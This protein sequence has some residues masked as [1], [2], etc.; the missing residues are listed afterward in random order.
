MHK[1][2]QL[3]L[4]CTVWFMCI[5]AASLGLDKISAAEAHTF[6]NDDQLIAKGGGHH[7]GHHHHH[8]HHHHH[9]HH[10][11]HH[12]HGH[13]HHGW[14]HGGWN[15]NNYWNGGGYWGD[16]P[17]YFNDPNYYYDN[18]GIPSVPYTTVLPE[19]GTLGPT[20]ENNT[21]IQN[22]PPLINQTT[23]KQHASSTTHTNVNK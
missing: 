3:V 6:L 7:G 9:G 23:P 21:L 13:H 15:H 22:P 16:N 11:H 12:H 1:T 2:R 5:L 18:N 19:S 14:H 17:G 8:H 10:H 4:I 20:I